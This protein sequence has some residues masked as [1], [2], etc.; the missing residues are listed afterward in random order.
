VPY[1]PCSA[2]RE[3]TTV[4]SP[5]TAMI[6]ELLLATARASPGSNEDPAQPKI[7]K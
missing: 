1:S 7:N 3:A 6:E 5:C 2:T 4:N